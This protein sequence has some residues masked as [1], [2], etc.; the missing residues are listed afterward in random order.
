MGSQGVSKARNARTWPFL[1]GTVSTRMM[2]RNPVLLGRTPYIRTY[3]GSMTQLKPRI[4]LSKGRVNGRDT[5]CIR[6][7][8]RS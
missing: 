4:P 3:G 1:P 6:V 8:G 2:R 7:L 5:R